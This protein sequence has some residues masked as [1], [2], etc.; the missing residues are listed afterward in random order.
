MERQF[1]FSEPDSGQHETEACTG[2]SANSAGCLDC[3]FLPAYT[4]K[5][6]VQGVGQGESRIRECKQTNEISANSNSTLCFKMCV[7]YL[8]ISHCPYSI[9]GLLLLNGASG[10]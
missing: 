3:F 2:C 5:H 10:C 6:K 7:T 8:V 4:Q 9:P 1:G